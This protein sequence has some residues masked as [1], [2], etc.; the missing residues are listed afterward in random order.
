[1]IHSADMGRG[2]IGVIDVTDLM[3]N[4]IPIFF[5]YDHQLVIV[6]FYSLHYIHIFLS[7]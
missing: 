3:V 5:S 1:M 7:L 2:V 4:H 6:V